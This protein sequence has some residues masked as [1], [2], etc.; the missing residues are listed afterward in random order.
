[1]EVST[2]FTTIRKPERPSQ[3]QGTGKSMNVSPTGSSAILQESRAN[4]AVQATAA[5]AAAPDL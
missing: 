4:K 3:F 5:K 2:T 1:M